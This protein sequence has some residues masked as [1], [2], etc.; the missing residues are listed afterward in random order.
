MRKKALSPIVSVILIIGLTIAAGA[1][2]FVVV[3]NLSENQ[4]S[5][6]K[7]CLNL[8][9]KIQINNDYTCYNLSGKE[10]RFSLSRKEIVLDYLL[11]SVFSE[12]ES[13]NFKLY[14]QELAVE[15]V[16]NYPSRTGNVS[17]PGNESGKTYI[18]NWS[19][20]TPEGIKISPSINNK[21]CE[22]ID[23]VFGIPNCI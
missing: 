22:V 15:A 5:G 12:Q 19:L 9:E 8:F 1:I 6:A 23:E 7:A 18:L 14:D 3:K 21:N 20:G 17:L 10:I 2:V 13:I 4:L 16:S 11:V